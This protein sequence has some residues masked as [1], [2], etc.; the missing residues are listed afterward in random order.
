MTSNITIQF[1]NLQLDKLIIC[2][3]ELLYMQELTFFYRANHQDFYSKKFDS[4]NKNIEE[5]LRH[6]ISEITEEIINNY[7]LYQNKTY[8]YLTYYAL[9]EKNIENLITQIKNLSMKITQN[10]EEYFDQYIPKALMG[11]RYNNKVITHF[12]EDYFHSISKKYTEE[13]LT[14]NLIPIIVW[15]FNN[16]YT[17]GQQISNIS[18]S[19]INNAFWYYEIPRLIPNLVHEI[20]HLCNNSGS[21]K[22]FKKSILKQNPNFKEGLIDEIYGDIIAIEELGESYILS[23]FYTISHND[24]HDIFYNHIYKADIVPYFAREGLSQTLLE[25]LQNNYIRIYV[26][27]E[28]ILNNEEENSASLIEHIKD[29]QYFINNYFTI[30]DIDNTVLETLENQYKLYY[31]EHYEEY[32]E[33]CDE[34]KDFGKV[35]LSHIDKIPTRKTKSKEIDYKDIFNSKWEKRLEVQSNNNWYHKNDL[36]KDLLQNILGVT[37]DLHAY[38]L[39]FYKTRF[40]TSNEFQHDNYPSHIFSNDISQESQELFGLFNQFKL[41]RKRE[42]IAYENI[43]SN[44][45]TNEMES[46]HS[47]SYTIRYPL[48][49]INTINP[50]SINLLPFGLILQL[51]LKDM[52]STTISDAYNTLSSDNFSIKCCSA[53]Y[54]IY[55][56]LGPNDYILIFEALS[57]DTIFQLKEYL[58]SQQTFRRT[59]TI[60]YRNNLDN[61]S[62]SDDTSYLIS[63]KIR[64]KCEINR[65]NN[66]LKDAHL[67]G[68]IESINHTPGSTDITIIWKNISVIL[69]YHDIFPKIKDSFQNKISDIQTHIS[70]QINLNIVN[71]NNA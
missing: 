54:T 6:L 21:F 63:S 17:V 67:I 59:S 38:E 37:N 46:N 12:F 65:F 52:N 13:K 39:I 50:D 48:T 40:D 70:K 44:F 51:Q 23:L 33:F 57:L 7:K 24:F 55:K 64:L 3:K 53:K 22:E 58:S 32:I 1:R 34:I 31:P 43:T 41:R 20:G 9:T 60:I 35:I 36:R 16:N 45:L 49:R 29:I 10:T 47:A 14:E 8:K 4:I 56:S 61:S 18:H 2:K 5:L 69:F 27:I 66:L 68:Y 62:D 30:F 26:L 28:A 15:D 71:K 19:I 25:R 11:R 42:T